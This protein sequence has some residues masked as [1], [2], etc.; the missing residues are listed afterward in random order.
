M[1]MVSPSCVVWHSKPASASSLGSS[2]ASSVTSSV[3]SSSVTSSVGSSSTSSVGSSSIT[4]S[5]GS[6]V[7]SSTS[8][9]ASVGAGAVGVACPPQATR[10]MITRKAIIVGSLFFMSNPPA[11][12]GKSIV[13]QFH[14]IL[15]WYLCICTSFCC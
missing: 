13:N 7:G 14:T 5:V 1:V 12:N 15:D 10:T 8:S 2:V 4:S 11:Q 6:S 9:T 3:G